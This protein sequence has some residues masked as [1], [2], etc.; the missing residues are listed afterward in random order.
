[1]DEVTGFGELGLSETRLEAIRRLGWTTPTPIQRKA[2]PAALQGKDLVGIAQTGT[3]KTGAFILPSLERIHEGKGLQILVLCPTREL[4]QQVAEDARQMAWGTE[5]RVA[6]IVGGV[7]YGPQVD[8]LRGGFEII[9]ATPGRL[10]DHLD[11][12]NVELKGLKVLVL[13]E[14]DRMLDMGFRP[15]IESILRKAPPGRQSMLFSATMPNGV[16]ALA[17]R[18]TKEALWVEAAPAG[19][20]A[21]GIEETVYT[22]KPRS[23]SSVEP[24]SGPRFSVAG[25]NARGSASRACTPI[26]GCRSE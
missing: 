8:A 1:L 12:G 17:L 9:A 6:D 24:R 5:L 22:V 11:R 3:G 13:D 14:A 15:Q 20:T 16:H 18:I 19:T 4:A 7:G 2:T 25:W 10:N 26:G 21:E 23:W